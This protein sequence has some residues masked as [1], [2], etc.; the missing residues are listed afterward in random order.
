MYQIGSSTT[1]NRART[2]QIFETCEI[3]LL[4]TSKPPRGIEILLAGISNM[5]TFKGT[6]KIWTHLFRVGGFNP[7]AK[8]MSIKLDHF[9]K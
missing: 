9:P 8:N 7:S 4:Q 6:Q 3:S 2:Q 1:K 5:E